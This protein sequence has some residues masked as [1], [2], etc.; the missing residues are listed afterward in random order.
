MSD[1][2]YIAYVEAREAEEFRLA[3]E[4]WRDEK[5]SGGG[6]AVIVEVGGDF[7]LTSEI[8]GEILTNDTDSKDKDK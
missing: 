6:T 2:E 4:A 8:D 3:V 1:E 7:A 5:R